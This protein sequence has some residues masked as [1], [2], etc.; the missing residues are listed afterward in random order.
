MQQP[1]TQAIVSSTVYAA[2][3]LDRMPVCPFHWR[4]MFLIGAGLF[5]DAFDIYIGGGVLGALVKE[6]WS[7]LQLNATFV[8][9]TFA[10]LVVG[11][12]GSGIL[13]DQFGRRFSY[14]LNLAIFG[15][16]SLAAVFAPNMWTL[17][18][19]RFIMG[20]GLGAELVIGYAAL[21]EFV[22]PSQRGRLVA[23][24]SFLANSAVF[25]ASLI[26]LWVIPNLGWRYMFLIVGIAALVVWF[27][28]KAL[29]ES[30]RWLESK[31]RLAEAEAVLSSIEAEAKSQGTPLPEFSRDVSRN[32]SDVSI[33]AVFRG[34]Y[35]S[36]TL[37]GGLIFIVIG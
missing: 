9:M 5:L 32:A 16:A 1:T 17:I 23:F 26:G 35:L 3:R 8:T 10:G 21:A 37:I 33:A 31:G 30:P 18:A 22:P 27:L 15:L 2:A 25:I 20:V 4:I 28:R 24:L 29:P 13:G 14:Q 34:T 19:L 6:G 7:T 36:R 11:A 12:W